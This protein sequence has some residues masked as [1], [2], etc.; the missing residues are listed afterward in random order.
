MS[1]DNNDFDRGESGASLTE[2]AEAGRM[3]PGSLIMMKE[4]FPCKVTAFSTAKPGKHGS[5]KAMITAKDIFTDK[6]YDE[7]FG[8]GD[9]IPRPLVSKAEM[10]VI[11]YED[12]GV[13][14]IMT[15]EGEMKEDLNLPTESHLSDITSKIK[16]IV[17]A[18]DKECLIQVQRW[19]DK[20]QVV[21]VREGQD[22]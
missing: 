19:G 17:D 3:K 16:Q 1:S 13:L 4:T 15:Q 12:D 20:E 2:L 8:T 21:G 9:M 7:T 6:Q 11:A 14:Q 18:A 22:Q 10:T 5:A